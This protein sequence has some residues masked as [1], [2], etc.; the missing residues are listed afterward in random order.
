VSARRLLG[1]VCCVTFW[2]TGRFIG[3][4]YPFS[5]LGMFNESVTAASRLFAKNA[6]GEATEIGRWEEWRC[7]GPLDFGPRGAPPCSAPGYS[8]YDEIVRDHI[9]SHPAAGK[10]AGDR[11]SVQITR[12]VFVVADPTGPVEITDCPLLHCTAR[13]RS[14]APWIPRL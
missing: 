12:R 7:D 6:A 3:E 1:I 14:P 2:A 11:E 5:P 10:D 4:F 9:Q 13:R 8:A